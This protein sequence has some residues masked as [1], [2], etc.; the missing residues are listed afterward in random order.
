MFGVKREVRCKTGAIP[1][2]VSSSGDEP[3][4]VY[5]AATVPAYPGREGSK[6]GTSQKT[7]QVYFFIT[8]LSGE[9]PEMQ[10]FANSI[11][12]RTFISTYFIGSKA[13]SS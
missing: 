6:Q 2:A 9:R 3:E 5:A 10:V 13:Y 1:V 7:C 11:C 4:T 8:E 12:C